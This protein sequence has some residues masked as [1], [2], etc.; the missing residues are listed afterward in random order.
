MSYVQNTVKFKTKSDRSASSQRHDSNR[1]TKQTGFGSLDRLVEISKPDVIR[2]PK[3]EQPAPLV[4]EGQTGAWYKTVRNGQVS[5]I[6]LVEVK[7]DQAVYK[8]DPNDKHSL[9]ISLA[10]FMK[11]YKIDA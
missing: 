10:K 4:F 5:R 8:N 9:S 2:R 7:K 3:Q 6:W 11:F 1:P